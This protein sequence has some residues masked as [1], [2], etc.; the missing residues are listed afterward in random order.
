MLVNNIIILG[1]A[2]SLD[3]FGVAL[4]IGCSKKL[5]FNESGSLIFSFGFFQFLFVFLGGIMGYFINTNLF[6][7][8]G[9]ISGIII[10][11]VGIML[12]KEGYENGEECV[13]YNFNL[14]KYIV[15]GISVSMDALGVGFSILYRYQIP[16]LLVNSLLVGA[17]TFLLTFISLEITKYIKNFLI[18]E[19]YSDY[20]GGII[21]VIFGLK[22]IF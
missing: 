11:L 15:L 12:L 6:K 16:V 18:I 19:K 2:L 13:Y 14:W 1:L 3:A 17:I 21:L 8:S 20:I 22:M 9:Y 10:L 7:I 4:G 5:K